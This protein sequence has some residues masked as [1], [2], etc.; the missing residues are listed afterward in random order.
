[1]ITLTRVHA[2]YPPL[3]VLDGISLAIGRG[4]RVALIGPNGAGKSSL[5]K[6]ISGY[7]PAEGGGV[8]IKGTPVASLPPRQRARILSVVPQAPPPDIPYPAY[9]FVMLGRSATLPRFG[10]PAEADRDAVRRAMELTG[11]WH[12]RARP[13]PA[14][15]GGER[16]RLALA[17]ALAPDPE[18]ILLD[19]PTS[20]LD[21]RHRAALT[22]LL[23]RLNEARRI[24][25]VMAVHDLT[26]ASQFFP[27]V[28]LL[29]GGRKL[30][31][32]SPPEVLTPPLL[33]AAY[34]CPVR[35]HPLPDGQGMC[36]LPSI[37]ADAAI[38][39]ENHCVP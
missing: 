19:E 27:R 15:S 3:R 22:A 20:H 8:E 4:E 39:K 30:A 31:D 16:Q 18:I 13:V 23:V 34:H 33:E 29:A 37:D 5:L 28:V 6:V 25:L 17:M 14:M 35:I 38:G 7:L 12:L 9:D 11:T 26:L 1:M 2:S 24:T 21:L 10:G 32:G 36:V